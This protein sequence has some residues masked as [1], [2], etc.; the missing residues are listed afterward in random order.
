M[1]AVFE[2]RRKLRDRHVCLFRINFL[3]TQAFQTKSIQSYQPHWTGFQKEV[4][5]FPPGSIQPLRTRAPCL[6]F[7]PF[8]C[9]A[10]LVYKKM[11]ILFVTSVSLVPIYGLA[12]EISVSLIIC[13]EFLKYQQRAGS[14]DNKHQTHGTHAMGSLHKL[15]NRCVS[16]GGAPETFLL[17]P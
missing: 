6:Y 12:F 17:W 3:A 1:H 8:W 13:L 5:H 2:R 14:Q 16:A 10:T 15:P 11:V 9:Y 7:F 4:I